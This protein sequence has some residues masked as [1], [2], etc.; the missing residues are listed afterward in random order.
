[1]SSY[2]LSGGDS[3]FLEKAID[4][5]DRILPAF[6][7]LTG[8]PLPE[9]NLKERE[10][11]DD[12]RSPGLI[13]TA[14]ASTLQLELKYLSFLTDNDVYW[15]RA[16]KVLLSNL[17]VDEQDLATSQV[18]KVIKAATKSADSIL[19]PIFMGFV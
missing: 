1:M 2:H 18:M 17:G 13:S 12:P 7:T 5:A 6:D 16:E 14:E 9:I 8:L 4:L 10:G 11:V 19:V 15:E 3:L